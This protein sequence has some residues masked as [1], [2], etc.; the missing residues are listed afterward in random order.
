MEKQEQARQQAASMRAGIHLR[1]MGKT[2]FFDKCFISS[3]DRIS[4]FSTDVKKNF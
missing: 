2:S 4:N 3:N 1:N